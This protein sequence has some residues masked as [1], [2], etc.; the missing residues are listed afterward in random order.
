[1]KAFLQCAFLLI[2]GAMLVSTAEASVVSHSYIGTISEVMGTPPAQAAV[3]AAIRLSY[4]VEAATSDENSLPD[5]GI[6]LGALQSL[7][8]ELPG[9]EPTPVGQ[10]RHGANIRQHRTVR[11]H[12]D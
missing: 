1:M 8:V 10:R 6:F 5:Q 2:G 4:T 7:R 12:P 3:G 9:H 11:D